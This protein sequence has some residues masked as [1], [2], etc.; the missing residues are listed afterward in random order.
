[1]AN[2]VIVSTHCYLL[3]EAINSITIDVTQIDHSLLRKEEVSLAE[4]LNNVKKPKDSSKRPHKNGNI[5][6]AAHKL[7]M[8]EYAKKLEATSGFQITINYQPVNR[9]LNSNGGQN[10]NN[11]VPEER[12]CQFTVLGYDKAM[13]VYRGVV[14]QIRQQIPDQVFLNDLVD[15]LFQEI[16]DDKNVKTT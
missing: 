10:H 4:M 9:N 5:A 7:A 3:C 15:R 8:E 11:G 1:M 2:I 6:S 16:D 12:L 13:L 14:E